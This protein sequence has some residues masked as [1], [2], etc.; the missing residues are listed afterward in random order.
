MKSDTHG[1]ASKHT[2]YIS[3]TH[4]AIHHILSSTTVI[5][6]LWSGH[7]NVFGRISWNHKQ[8][9]THIIYIFP[10]NMPSSLITDIKYTLPL[11]GSSIRHIAPCVMNLNDKTPTSRKF[12]NTTV[13]RYSAALTCWL[14]QIWWQFLW[15][16]QCSTFTSVSDE[17]GYP[18]SCLLLNTVS[19][20]ANS[21]TWT[22]PFVESMPQNLPVVYGYNLAFLTYTHTFSECSFA[23]ISL[24]SQTF[25]S[26]Y[27]NHPWHRVCH[28]VKLK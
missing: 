10:S 19:S 23:Y 13:M 15:P 28:L 4:T 26:N 20:P 8:A 25:S 3:V 18:Q 21:L 5:A 16:W 2:R 7:T 24:T 9:N 6:I 14:F 27:S 17:H 1:P 22:A 12:W 11:E